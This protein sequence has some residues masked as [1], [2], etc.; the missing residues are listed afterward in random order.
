MATENEQKLVDLCFQT[1]LTLST[2]GTDRH[3]QPY[4]M[5]K[6]PIEKKAEWVAKQLRGC[7]FDTTPCG[8]LW[9]VLK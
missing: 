5:T 6:W 1:A 7:G 8:S 4:D 3:D 9:G 2:P